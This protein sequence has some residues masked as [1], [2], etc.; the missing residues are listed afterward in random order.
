[1]SV[2]IVYSGIGDERQYLILRAAGAKDD[3]DWVWRPPSGGIQPCE[4]G[5]GCAVRDL[6]EETGLSGEL[7]EV[8]GAGYPT[9]RF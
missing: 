4:S 7:R 9:A 1:M 3:G 6:M 8:P 5:A 2:I